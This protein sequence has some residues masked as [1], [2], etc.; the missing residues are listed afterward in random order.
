MHVSK[1]STL[2]MVDAI[3]IQKKD[4]GQM[5]RGLVRTRSY[6]CSCTN[7]VVVRVFCFSRSAAVTLIARCRGWFRWR[8]TGKRLCGLGEVFVVRLEE[9]LLWNSRWRVWLA[10]RLGTRGR[11]QILWVACVWRRSCE[12]ENFL[13]L[14]SLTLTYN[15][16]SL[17][18]CYRSR[19]WQVRGLRGVLGMRVK[20]SK[21]TN[22]SL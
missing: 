13:C 9:S 11:I 18:R 20:I 6:A 7:T 5:S 15:S 10:G 1:K 16:S 8:F 21:V 19:F 3:I 2:R 17:C 12:F 4:L 14:R 22:F